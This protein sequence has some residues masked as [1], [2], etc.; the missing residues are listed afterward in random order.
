MNKLKEG[1]AI[2]YENNNK[3]AIYNFNW[4]VLKIISKSGA[5]DKHKTS[6]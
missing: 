6:I 3:Q 4:N 1:C 2:I 5:H